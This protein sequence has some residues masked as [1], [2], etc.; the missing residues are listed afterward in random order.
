MN[1]YAEYEREKE[2]LRKQT[3]SPEEY[4]QAVAAI[5]RRLGI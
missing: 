5:A 1:K 3:L 4:Q 2:K